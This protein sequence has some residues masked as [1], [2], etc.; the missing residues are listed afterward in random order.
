M[1]MFIGIRYT[2]LSCR[3]SNISFK[4][5]SEKNGKK[6]KTDSIVIASGNV[7]IIS[8]K[9]MLKF[10]HPNKSLL[11]IIIQCIKKK[12]FDT[13]VQEEATFKINT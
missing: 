9:Q 5:T 4:N 2:L 8:L 10:N 12:I 11:L 1:G 3:I 6:T 7:S 13:S